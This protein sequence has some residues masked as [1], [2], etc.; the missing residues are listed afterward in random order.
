MSILRRIIPELR[1]I[2]EPSR[3]VNAGIG[4]GVTHLLRGA[5]G[6]GGNMGSRLRGGG[7]GATQYAGVPSLFGVQPSFLRDPLEAL[8]SGDLSGVVPVRQPAIDVRETDRAY[9]IEAE[10]PGLNKDEVDIEIVDDDTL[11]IS[12]RFETV[13][14]EG[15][16]PPDV[17]GEEGGTAAGTAGAGETAA[18]DTGAA[19]GASGATN[20][21]TRGGAG[22]ETYW[23]M[24]RMVGEFRRAITFPTKLNP[25]QIEAT[26]KDGILRIVVPKE[27]TNTKKIPIR[28]DAGRAL[29][30]GA[31]AGSTAGGSTSTFAAD[32]A[33]RTTATP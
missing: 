32:E 27:P 5:G 15:A 1:S 33:G 22:R 11:V 30:G 12:G 23:T 8:A 14:E 2:I 16:P 3:L 18:G 17:A 9:I 19:A 21:G 13:R 7:G 31:G 20:A 25:E 28:A 4:S 10:L 29:P 6:G 26:V 24:E